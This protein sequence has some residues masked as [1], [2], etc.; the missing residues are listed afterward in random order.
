M[1][2]NG[3]IQDIPM[4][5]DTILTEVLPAETVRQL[6]EFLALGKSGQFT[7]HISEGR[8]VRSETLTKEQHAIVFDKI[9]QLA[10][11]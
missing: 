11:G 3:G 1:R 8:P 6:A 5:H 4:M 7:I 10:L 9:T 2:T